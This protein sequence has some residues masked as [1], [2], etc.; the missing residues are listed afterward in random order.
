MQVI[1]NTCH[2]NG[3]QLLSRQRHS[4]FNAACWTLNHPEWFRVQ[5]IQ[6]NSA[7]Y[8]EF[9]DCGNFTHQNITGWFESPQT[10][11]VSV[12]IRLSGLEHKEKSSNFRILEEDANE[13]N[14]RDLLQN[15]DTSW[16]SAIRFR[17]LNLLCER[18]RGILFGW[19]APRFWK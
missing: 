10:L 2:F 11:C 14:R 16:K 12:S 6:R 9:F 4:Y 3:S 13:G 19:M 18:E 1:V 8:H 15:C 17:K 5:L 7:D